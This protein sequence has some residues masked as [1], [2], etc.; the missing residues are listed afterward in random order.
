MARDLAGYK[1]YRVMSTFTDPAGR[2]TL[3]DYM[4]LPGV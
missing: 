3:K 4:A 2:A 1:P